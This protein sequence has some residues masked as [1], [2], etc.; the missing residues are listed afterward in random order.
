LQVGSRGCRVQFELSNFGFELQVECT[1]E[2]RQE[3]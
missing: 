1:P 3:N 2:M